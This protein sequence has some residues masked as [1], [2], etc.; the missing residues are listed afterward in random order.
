MVDKN[1]F[2]QRKHSEKMVVCK[3]EIATIYVAIR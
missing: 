1:Y 2:F 3:W